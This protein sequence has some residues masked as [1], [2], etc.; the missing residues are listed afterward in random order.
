MW[1]WNCL[2]PTVAA[3]MAVNSG[4]LVISPLTS[5]HFHAVEL[6]VVFYAY[7]LAHTVI[8]CH[9]LMN[10]PLQHTWLT[11][12]YDCN[13]ELESSYSNSYLLAGMAASRPNGLASY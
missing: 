8:C 12:S 9:C 4:H 11:N 13:W 7:L 5:L 6:S 1:N 3:C 10:F 2:T